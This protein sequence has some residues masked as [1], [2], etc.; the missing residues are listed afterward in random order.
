MAKQ[1]V[2]L[3]R[4]KVQK[5]PVQNSGKTQE[6]IVAWGNLLNLPFVKITN[7]GKR[8][9][10]E[11]NRFK[12]EGLRPGFPDL[13]L[14]KPRGAYGALFIEVKTSEKDKLRENQSWWLDW[15]NNNGYKAVVCWSLDMAIE[16]VESYLQ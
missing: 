8:S 11:A 15:L 7:E 6:S 14:L 2:K 10:W 13:V 16:A 3:K 1:A 4:K 5:I 12:R 9:F